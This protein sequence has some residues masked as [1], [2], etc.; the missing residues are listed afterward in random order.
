MFGTIFM[1]MTIV[2][3]NYTYAHG[4]VDQKIIRHYSI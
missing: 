4:M 3:E 1:Q 2:Q